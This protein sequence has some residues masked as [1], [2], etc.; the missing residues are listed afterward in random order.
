[1]AVLFYTWLG[2][3]GKP[4]GTLLAIEDV[5]SELGGKTLWA[6]ISD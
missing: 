5:A 3:S 4:Q 1:M 2:A 6:G